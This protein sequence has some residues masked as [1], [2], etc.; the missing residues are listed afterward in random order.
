MRRIF[1][2]FICIIAFANIQAQER[3]IPFNGILTDFSLNPIKKARVYITSP[4]RYVI[5]TKRGEFGLTNVDTDDTLKISIKERTYRVPIAKCKSLSI[6]LNI[7]TGEILASESQELIEKG[8]DHVNRREGN[9]GTIISGKALIRSG[10][11]TLMAAL[12]GRVPGLNI[13]GIE[14]PGSDGSVNIRGLKS[15]MGSNTP[16]FVVDGMIVETLSDIPLYDIDYV[17]ILK[18]AS[19]YGSRGANGAI[20]VF[21]RLP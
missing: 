1:I 16:L 6:M 4:R 14:A 15:F 3:R 5:T 12:Q 20:I 13:S 7:E 17:E 10:H 21:T 8:F 9:L 11:N 2:L 18:E 19:H